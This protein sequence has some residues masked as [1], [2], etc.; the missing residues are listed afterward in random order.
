MKLLAVLIL[1]IIQFLLYRIAIP[2][3]RKDTSQ[4]TGIPRK[5]AADASEVV[6]K[7]RFV[8]PDAGQLRPTH[9]TSLK[10]DLQEE[11]PFTFAAGNGKDDAV[12]PPETLYEVFA[13]D[14]NPEDLDIPPDDDDESEVPDLEE[15]SADLQ[16]TPDGSAGM[17]DG[18]SIEE[19]TEA[20]EAIGN[21][22]DEHAGILYRVET[23]DMF[24]QLVSGDEGKAVQIKSIIERLISSERSE[25]RESNKELTG[26]SGWGNFDMQQYLSKT[27]KK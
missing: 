27:G 19:L 17:A 16:Q 6:V 8:R 18:L 14:P 3:K 23:T 7:T 21:P 9:T 4:C 12:I 10:T 15:E 5:R 11:K 26:D 25:S 24:E 13:D 2:K 20:V 1:L 22:T